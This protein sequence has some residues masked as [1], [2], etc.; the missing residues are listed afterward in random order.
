[1]ITKNSIVDNLPD[2]Y[3]YYSIKKVFRSVANKLNLDYLTSS[4]KKIC[5]FYSKTNHFQFSSLNLNKNSIYLVNSPLIEGK[6]WELKLKGI[7]GFIIEEYYNKKNYFKNKVVASLLTLFSD[8]PFIVQTKRTKEFLSECNL[9]TFFFPP[10]EKKRFSNKERKFFLFVGRMVKSKNPFLI[11]ELAKI[12]KKENFVMIGRGPLLN[13]VKVLASNLKNVKII[14]F[15]EDREKLFSDYYSK[16][17]A[18]IH[19]AFSDPIGHVIIE[20]LSTGTPVIASAFTGSSDYLLRDWTFKNFDIHSIAKKIQK[21]DEKDYRKAREIFQKEN[22]DIQSPYFKKLE[23]E[24]LNY[25]I[26]IR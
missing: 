15:I 18:L 8:Y 14:E 13:K 16:A 5:F 9:K 22:L 2:I 10:A 20:S 4:N 11:I 12:L 6:T 7:D 1:M 3:V 21:I 17:K 23:K 19:P 24:V 25:L 26:N